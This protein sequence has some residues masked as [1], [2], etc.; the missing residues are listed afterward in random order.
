MNV[1]AHQYAFLMDLS[2]TIP[3]AFATSEEEASEDE[4]LAQRATPSQS[5]EQSAAPTPGQTID[6]EQ[7][8]SETVDLFPELAMVAVD[9]QGH[10]TTLYSKLEFAFRCGGVQLE[11]FTPEAVTK[12]SLKA[13]S[14]ARFALNDVDVKY[15]M[16]SNG[17]SEAEVL[18]KSF[19][20]RFVEFSI[21]GATLTKC[22]SSD[23]P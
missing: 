5:P 6:P 21:Q 2:K 15:K 8:P 11:L 12:A 19:V 18:L 7:K 23:G 14:L 17:S 13:N 3:R 20:G 4:D 10:K 1:T 9:E 22:M 16:V